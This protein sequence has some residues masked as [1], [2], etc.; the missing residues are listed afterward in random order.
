MKK[1][2]EELS[3]LLAEAEEKYKRLLI[4][5][6]SSMSEEELYFAFHSLSERDKN[7]LETFL[8]VKSP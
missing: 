7:I 6:I 2:Y 1:T 8:E 4:N 5:S 3:A